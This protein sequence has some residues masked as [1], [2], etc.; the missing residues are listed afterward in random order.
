MCFSLDPVKLPA[1]HLGKCAQL[2]NLVARKGVE[3]QKVQ[4]QQD[5]TVWLESHLYN[6]MQ[7][8]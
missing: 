8:A 2:L 1:I 5:L 7:A 3:G 4:K 6:V